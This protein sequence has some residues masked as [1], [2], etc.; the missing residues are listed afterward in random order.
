MCRWWPGSSENYSLNP[1]YVCNVLTLL[2]KAVWNYSQRIFSPFFVKS[3]KTSFFRFC[4]DCDSWL[5]SWVAKI[6]RRQLNCFAWF[7]LELKIWIVFLWNTLLVHQKYCPYLKFDSI[8]KLLSW[9]QTVWLAATAF[10]IH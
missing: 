4:S 5:T 9:P 6:S 10:Q 2:K 3:P 1:C 8:I 7:F